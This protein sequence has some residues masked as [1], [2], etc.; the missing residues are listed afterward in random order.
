VMAFDGLAPEVI[1]GRA[2]SELF[3]CSN[4]PQGCVRAV[5][6]GTVCGPAA[7]LLYGSCRC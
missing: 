6:A 3:A 2:A 5:I 4:R 1:N 7:R